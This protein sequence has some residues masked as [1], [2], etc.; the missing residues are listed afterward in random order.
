MKT[1]SI[2][3]IL[4]ILCIGILAVQ[5]AASA[6]P[7]ILEGSLQISSTPAGATIFI[8]GEQAGL[9]PAT[10]TNLTLG[11]HDVV[12]RKTGYQDWGT[13]AYVH[14]RQTTSVSAILVPLGPTVTPT[15]TPTT[16]I[17]PTPTTITPTPTITPVLTGSLSV[18]STPT[19]AAVMV[20]NVFVGRT[21]LIRS[22]ITAGTHKVEV[23]KD[24]YH[25]YEVQVTVQ[26][27]STTTVIANLV[28]ETPAT[29]PITTVPTT[30]PTTTIPTTSPTTEPTTTA[31]TTVPTTTP[32][33]VTPTTTTTV[34]PTG[35]LQVFSTPTNASVRVDNVFVGK[36]PLFLNGVAA[37]TH[38]VE[39]DK[40][41]YHSYE[42][43]VTVQAGSTTTLIATLIPETP[44]PTPT[45]T[46]TPPPTFTPTTSPTTTIPTTSPTTEPTTTATTTVPTTTP[47]T[48]T[49]TTTT[50]VT[51]TGTLQVFSTPTNASVRVDNVF[52]GKTPLFLNGVAAGTHKVEVDKEGFHSYEAQVQVQ[53]GSTT[54]VIATLIPETQT[55]TP[56]TTTT[57]PT[58]SP[59]TGP[60]T[61][62]P[63]T[64]PTT[65]PTTTATTTV[66]TTAPTTVTPTTTTTV[67]PT[68]MLQVFSTPTNASVMVDNVFVGKTP[69]FLNGVAAG[70][71]KVEVDK[72]GYHSY[73]T[74]VQVQAGSTTTV[75]ATL[76]PETQTA[77]PTTTT[78]VPT[79]SPTTGPTTV[80]PTTT[81]TVTP[82]GM[83][84]VFSTPTNASVRMDDA[85]AGRTP[86]FLNGVAAGTHKV[87]VDKEGYH[88]YEAQVQVQ[89]GSTTTVIATLIPEI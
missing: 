38:K 59:T 33:T 8:D 42:T 22:G 73:E 76:I 62:T 66:P 29:T 13:Q 10:V 88:S 9:T 15:V 78:T 74:L 16:T 86:L 63:T 30:S 14:F 32:T 45:I 2:A 27:G 25:S 26:S 69:L 12:L 71:H 60:T 39:V 40:E 64:S 52:V 19:N 11:Y 18:F 82:T 1:Y 58:T 70:T 72:E 89:G 87:E 79:T 20:D 80:T 49:P 41:G 7:F 43:Q 51:P 21:P 4:T 5:P 50:T 77:T 17:T 48:V 53:A 23:D 36:T 68:G 37:G 65:E 3:L 46:L 55:A 44:T 61:T 84:Q 34:T 83:L 67:T 6:P 28:P 75:I 57:V 56:T 85:F 35:T 81:T 47:T 31:T 54:T 24:G